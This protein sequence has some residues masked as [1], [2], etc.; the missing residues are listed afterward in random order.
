MKNM[1]KISILLLTVLMAGGLYACTDVGSSANTSGSSQM[2]DAPDGSGEDSYGD[3]SN[4][5]G[6]PPEG[7]PD[8][9]PPEK[10]NGSAPP[11]GTP[12]ERPGEST[13]T[14]YTSSEAASSSAGTNDTSS[15]AANSS[16]TSGTSSKS[17][18]SSAGASDTS[19]G[20]T[21]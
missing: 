7:V 3:E 17:T 2:K 12:P 19:F 21:S 15:K 13:N 11:E 20:K 4:F 14:D 9:A 6:K 5:P 16:G 1:K 18:S 8:G 10:P